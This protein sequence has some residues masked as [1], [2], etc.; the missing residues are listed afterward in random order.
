M[1]GFIHMISLGLKSVSGNV[2]CKGFCIFFLFNF[3]ILF[4]KEYIPGSSN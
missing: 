1:K 2:E 3:C 4:L